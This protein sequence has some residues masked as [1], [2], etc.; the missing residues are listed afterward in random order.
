MHQSFVCRHHDVTS[1]KQGEA[2]RAIS[3]ITSLV[4]DMLSS[5]PGL[6]PD[7]WSLETLQCC[8]N[9]MDSQTLIVDWEFQES[10]RQHTPAKFYS[11]PLKIYHLK[12]KL[13]FQQS[14]FQGLSVK[15]RAAFFQTCS[16][17]PLFAGGRNDPV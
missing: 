4:N 15:L 14:I 6:Y 3:G 11:S 2:P 9:L 10:Y 7:C 8:D 12:R 1:E 17:Q 13:V 5:L 16:R